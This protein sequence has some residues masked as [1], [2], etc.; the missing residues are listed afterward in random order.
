MCVYIY[1]Y[2]KDPLRP[3]GLALFWGSHEAAITQMGVRRGNIQWSLIDLQHSC[4]T[5]TTN[6]NNDNDNTHDK[7]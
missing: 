7:Q 3:F 5:T 1:I 6:N 2:I 4:A